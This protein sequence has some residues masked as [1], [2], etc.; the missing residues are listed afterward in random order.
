MQLAEEF[1]TLSTEE[2]QPFQGQDNY[3]PSQ[4]ELTES[5]DSLVTKGHWDPIAYQALI[6]D[7][8]YATLTHM[9]AGRSRQIIERALRI[10]REPLTHRK[11]VSV[12]R[13][14]LDETPPSE[15]EGKTTYFDSGV[16]NLKLKF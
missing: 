11:Y 15:K 10:V 16:L 12:I 4:S 8:R 1:I 14:G 9:S 7:A 3:S 2:S 6:Y 5:K 13:E